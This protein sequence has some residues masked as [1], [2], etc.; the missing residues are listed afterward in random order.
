MSNGIRQSNSPVENWF[1][2]VKN[3]N[4]DG[5]TN[6]R[7]T[8]FVRKIRAKVLALHRDVKLE[9]KQKRVHTYFDQKLIKKGRLGLQKSCEE[10]KLEKFTIRVDNLSFYENGFVSNRNYYDDLPKKYGYYI[11]KYSDIQ[12]A[13]NEL[14]IN[15]FSFLRRNHVNDTDMYLTNFILDTVLHL[16]IIGVSAIYFAL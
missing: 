15:D 9:K 11:T 5:Q 7:P 3:N 2:L 16:Y 14:T 1:G 6:L 13:V 10:L 8:R 4:L 12:E